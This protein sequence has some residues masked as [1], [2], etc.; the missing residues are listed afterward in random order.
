METGDF[1]ARQPTPA[2]LFKGLPPG[3]R[4]PTRQ[5]GRRVRISGSKGGDTLPPSH[6]RSGR[7]SPKA[8]ARERPAGCWKWTCSSPIWE[9]FCGPLPGAPAAGRDSRALVHLCIRQRGRE[10]VQRMLAVEAWGSLY[11]PCSSVTWLESSQ[12]SSLPRPAQ[13]PR[14][15]G[16]AQRPP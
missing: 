9:T 1:P 12:D 6:S 2:Q 5:R 10:E 4:A 14:E 16:G 13:P 15:P 11:P 7:R 8:E 3:L